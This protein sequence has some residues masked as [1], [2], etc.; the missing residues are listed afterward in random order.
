MEPVYQNTSGLP[1]N[2]SADNTFTVF[3]NGTCQRTES[4]AIS[5]RTVYDDVLEGLEYVNIILLP[6]C[7]VVGVFGN[8]ITIFIMN[9]KAF[10]KMGSRFFLIALAVSDATLLLA[11]PF[12][13]MFVYELFGRDLRA[14]SEVG[15]KLFFWFFRTG[16]M[17]SSW[18]VVYL[19]LER[20]TAVLFPFKVKI[21]FS[22]RNCLIAIAAVYFVI[23]G[24][25]AGWTYCSKIDS[26][27]VC[28]PDSFDRKDS[29]A[30]T[31][32]RS[33]LTAG[34]SLYSLIP[35]IIIVTVTPIILVS[36]VRRSEARK[37][38]TKTKGNSSDLTRATT[39][40]VSVMVTYV[41]FVTPITALHNIAFYIGV[42]AFGQNT[43]KFLI[44]RDVSQILEQLNY[45]VN[46]FLYVCSSRPFRA[47]VS[48]ILRLEKLF[49][50]LQRLTSRSRSTDSKTTSITKSSDSGTHEKQ[51]PLDVEK[52]ASSLEVL[53]DSGD[54]ET[55]TCSPVCNATPKEANATSTCSPEGSATPEGVN[56]T[57]T[58]S[59][60]GSATPEEIK[61]N[62]E[63][64]KS[65]P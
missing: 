30:V 58:C 28:N 11:Q 53:Q 61:N 19:C 48:E 44:F 24:F 16:K 45:T 50:G 46:F 51:K 20:F 57:S 59:P 15:C 17:T 13:K 25:N 38:L 41:L 22:K 7:L 32:Y 35:I 43:K 64:Y 2:T 14:L 9:S 10:S 1:L 56:E 8:L 55:R 33:M 42:D 4:P 62:T 65:V 31:L 12:N 40:L 54:N 47:G 29:Q 23:G 5:P 60:D 36:L 34:S 27:G 39:M 49:D 26:K 6:T 21:F 52:R 37:K 3:C 18:F 63:I